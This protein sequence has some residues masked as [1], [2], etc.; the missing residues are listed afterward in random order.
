[1]NPSHA[2]YERLRGA[3][4]LSFCFAMPVIDSPYLSVGRGG[5]KS[6]PMFTC[7]FV[8]GLTLSLFVAGTIDTE[9][10]GMV[11]RSLGHQPTDDE[12]REM[13][14]EV[15]DESPAHGSS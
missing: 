5:A 1:M 6:T 11:M 7:C 10:L 12:V 13:I 4:V 8:R 15:S 14:N 3:N 9:E 2:R